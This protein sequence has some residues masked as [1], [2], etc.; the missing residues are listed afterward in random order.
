M[1]KRVSW[2]GILETVTESKRW[3]IDFLLLLE[4]TQFW[5]LSWPLDQFMVPLLCKAFFSWVKSSV[6]Y[7]PC[8]LM[9]LLC[10]KVFNWLTHVAVFL[11]LRID[12][13]FEALSVPV[14]VFGHRKIPAII[15][16]METSTQG[17]LI[18]L[19][20]FVLKKNFSILL[21]YFFINP[22]LGP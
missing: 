5:K 15:G 12:R 13:W 11:F 18:Q 10:H 9:Y 16:D 19:M 14:P 21:L 7:C 20:G 17:R 2:K 4:R 3:M 1:S 8:W 6:G 22:K